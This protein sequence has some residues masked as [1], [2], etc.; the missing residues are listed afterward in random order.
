MM[1][2]G[3]HQRQFLFHAAGEPAGLSRAKRVH[4]GHAQQVDRQTLPLRAHD[5]EQVGVEIHVLLYGEISIQAEALG[6]VADLVFHGL[7]LAGDIEAGHAR[8]A[9]GGVHQA[10]KHAQ[11][12]G[13][14]GAIGTHQAENLPTRYG[15]IEMVDGNDGAEAPGEIVS[16]DDGVHD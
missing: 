5:A 7:R 6:H 15:E 13:F 11:G 8:A 3:A 16:F 9:F 14:A 4:A 1:Q 2:Q 10:A 12:G